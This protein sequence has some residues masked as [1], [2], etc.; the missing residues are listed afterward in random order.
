MDRILLIEDA[1][2]FRTLVERT[3]ERE[4]AVTSAPDLAGARKHLSEG[5]FDLI[6][7]DVMLPDGD[8]IEFCRGLQADGRHSGV[9][10][11]ILTGKSDMTDKLSAFSG[12]ADD[13][14]V[15]PFHPLELKA[16]VE[17]RLHRAR[18]A[19]RGGDT[20]ELGGLR[21]TVPVQRAEIKADGQWR[22]LDLTPIEFKLLLFFVRGADRSHARADLI[23]SVWGEGVHVISRTVDAHVSNL[24]KKI[25]GCG[26]AVKSVHKVGYRFDQEGADSV[27]A[28]SA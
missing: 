15:K 14:L 24:R 2:D 12:G 8:G 5:R 13:Y 4:F 16:R 6:L 1:A 19:A 27:E 18:S 7:L 22:D 23:K 17:A 10:I 11:M 9:P 21:L 20:V 25:K 3:L 26:Y 28:E